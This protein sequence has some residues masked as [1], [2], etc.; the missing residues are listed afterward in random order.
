MWL[1]HLL[2]RINCDDVGEPEAFN[3]APLSGQNVFCL[4]NKK[5]LDSPAVIYYMCT[6]FISSLSDFYLTDLGLF[7]CLTSQ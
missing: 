4:D 1:S 2:L 5:K 7:V 6:T 3:P